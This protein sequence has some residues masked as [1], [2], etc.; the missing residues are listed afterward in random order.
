[1]NILIF[2]YSV[3]EREPAESNEK[4]KVTHTGKGEHHPF[5]D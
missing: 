2:D 1:M 4:D 5:E 3:L